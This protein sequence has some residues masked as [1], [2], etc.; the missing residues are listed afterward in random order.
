MFEEFEASRRSVDGI[1]YVDVGEGPVTVFVHGVFTNALLWRNVMRELA[2]TRR[3]IAVDLPG[4]GRTPP[5]G[6]PSVHGWVDAV[7]TV[8][9]ELDLRDVHLVGNDTGGAVVQLL[10]GRE[11]AGRLASLA[12]TNCDTELAFPPRLLKPLVWGARANV[13]RAIAPVLRFPFVAREVFRSGYRRPADVPREVFRSYLAPTVDDREG[14]RFTG[15]LLTSVHPRQLAENR[16]RL[17]ECE[18]PT[19]L[20]WGT[21]DLFFDIEQARWLR[22]VIPGARE[23]VEIHGGRLFFPDEYAAELVEALDHHWR[24]SV[25]KPS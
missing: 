15:R 2:G 4:H 1:S 22:D 18:L 16:A 23:I 11:E 5:I 8:L 24:T 17:A 12:L 13:L 25:G 3:C 7:A 19:A 14:L 10:L 9:R 21:G 20:I 6:E